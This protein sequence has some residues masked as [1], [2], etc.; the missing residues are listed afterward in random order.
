MADRRH[1]IRRDVHQGL[2]YGQWVPVYTGQAPAGHLEFHNAS[3]AGAVS[4][5]L[6]ASFPALWDSSRKCRGL[7]VLYAK[8]NGANLTGLL[9]TYPNRFPQHS[10]VIRGEP[11][12]DPRDGTQSFADPTTWK[13]SR[14]GVPD[15][16][17]NPALIWAHYWTHS[18]GGRLGYIDIDW[19]SVA[20]AANDCDRSVPTLGGGNEPFARCDMQW[21]AG[22][23][24]GEVE[25][26][27]GD[28]RRRS[29]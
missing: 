23:A 16:G 4:S 17:R 1:E 21:H 2:V 7:A 5:L 27:S 22:E 26:H 28:M 29:V 3:D 15:P 11:V 12:Y 9:N 25:A 24:P 14:S 18:D 6:S 20:Q 19:T 10:T 13:F 8:W